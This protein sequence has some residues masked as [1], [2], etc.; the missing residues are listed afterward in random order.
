MKKLV[1]LM[2]ALA[3]LLSLASIASA[4]EV[5]HLVTI[6]L[7]S[8]P[9]A[10]MPYWKRPTSILPKSTASPLKSVTWTGILPRCIPSS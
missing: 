4:D 5:T 1:S 7:G 2:L 10:T 6:S 8:K 3:L 9:V